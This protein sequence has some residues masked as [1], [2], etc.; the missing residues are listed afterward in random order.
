M[1]EKE[2][3]PPGAAVVGVDHVS[4]AV[5]DM[6]PIV[7]WYQDMF[8]AEVI[9]N[10]DNPETGMEWTH[11]AVGDSMVEFV[12][13]PELANAEGRIYGYHHVAFK[14]EDCDVLTQSMADKGATVMVPPNDFARHGIR[15]SFVRDCLGNVIELISPSP[16]ASGAANG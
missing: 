14:V 1:S 3:R 5:P 6:Q 13:I 16:D 7:S 10:W 11:L 4:L 2:L 15:W 12:K 8:G 9:D